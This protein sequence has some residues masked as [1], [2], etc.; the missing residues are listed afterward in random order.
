MY[1]KNEIDIS[2]NYLK[3]VISKINEPIVI[4]GGWATYFSVNKNYKKEFNSDY[5]GSRDVDLGFNDVKSLK[6]TTTI[7]EKEGFNF[8]SFRYLKEIHYDTGKELTKEE[9]ITLP[10]FKI[11]NMYVDVI[12][13][14]TN[15]EISKELGFHPVDEPLIKLIFQDTKYRIELIEFD[16]KLWLPSP[17]LLLAGKVNSIVNR[18]MDHK[19][20]KDYCD[21]IALCLYSEED[22][23]HIIDLSKK[24]ILQENIIKLNQ[25]I[26]NNDLQ[27]VSTILTIDINIIKQ[28]LNKII[29]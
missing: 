2:Y 14:E 20:I 9:S 21:I 29:S 4:I 18:T 22:I 28:I 1:D 25:L 3:K 7:L 16:R 15:D 24:Y 23:N 19:R 11:F 5:L 17:F 6:E 26:N 10:G 8:I 13:S 27:Q 12:I